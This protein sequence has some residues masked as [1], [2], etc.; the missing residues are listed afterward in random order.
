MQKENIA[1]SMTARPR[2]PR[3]RKIYLRTGRLNQA[4][5]DAGYAL[6]DHAGKIY[7]RAKGFDTAV[8]DS[9]SVGLA[10]VVTAAYDSLAI[11]QAV[12]NDFRESFVATS[13]AEWF[14]EKGFTEWFCIGASS[15]FR[16]SLPRTQGWFPAPDPP[17]AP[18][19]PKRDAKAK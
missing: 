10:A 8:R 16:T 13:T 15:E 9:V 2:C 7:E 4:M 14:R 5:A 17:I 18:I 1:S 3:K 12:P 19:R 11:A 6:L